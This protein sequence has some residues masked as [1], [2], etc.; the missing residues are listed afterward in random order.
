MIYS[1]NK[2]MRKFLKIVNILQVRSNR[3]RAIKLGR[4]FD[5]AYRL[6]PWHPGTYILIPSIFVIGIVMFGVVGFWEEADLVNP[7]KWN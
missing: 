3:G 1:K 5:E 7:F 6:N 2:K 4:G